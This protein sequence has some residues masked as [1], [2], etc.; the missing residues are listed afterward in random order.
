MAHFGGPYYGPCGPIP[1]G[2]M[3][4]PNPGIREEIEA[5]ERTIQTIKELGERAAKKDDTPKKWWRTQ[6]NLLEYGASLFAAF[7]LGMGFEWVLAHLH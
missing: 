7:V 1:D 3:R 5:A 4:M 2:Y 6:F